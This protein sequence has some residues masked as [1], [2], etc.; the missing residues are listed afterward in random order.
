MKF[1]N[2]EWKWKEST[3]DFRSIFARHSRQQEAFSLG[4]MSVS[5][6]SLLPAVYRKHKFDWKKYIL[7]G[8]PVP[9]VI[10]GILAQPHKTI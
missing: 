2:D 7:D 1:M 5:A 6:E 10:L 9:A 4:E 3:N 8:L